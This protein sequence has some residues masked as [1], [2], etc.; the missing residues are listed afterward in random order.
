[1]IK[2][3][4]LLFL[5]L[6]FSYHLEEV[7]DVRTGR[8]QFVESLVKLL[9]AVLEG[10]VFLV[11]LHTLLDDA[12][13]HIQAVLHNIQTEENLVEVGQSFLHPFLF[14]RIVFGMQYP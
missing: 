2:N 8:V 6:D 9:H 13:V 1:M 10:A 14:L 11:F 4:L 5:N 3:L 7:L 12:K